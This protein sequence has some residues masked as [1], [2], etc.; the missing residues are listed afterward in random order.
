MDTK[1]RQT[2]LA[3]GE[4]I[5]AICKREGLWQE[6]FAARIGVSQ[7]VISAWESGDTMPRKN[8]I[9]RIIEAVPDI[10]VDDI[11]SMDFGF[12]RRVSCLRATS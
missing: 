10:M 4:N 6:D 8:N 12:A 11:C 5:A 9:E 2:A 3:I 1:E 7:G